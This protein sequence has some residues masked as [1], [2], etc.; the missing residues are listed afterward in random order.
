MAYQDFIRDKKQMAEL[1]QQM[2]LLI[3]NYTNE[4]L[5]KR[6]TEWIDNEF[7]ENDWETREQYED[8]KKIMITLLAD[9][10]LKRAEE[11]YAQEE[12]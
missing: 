9:E 6:L 3:I 12:V 8:R 4:E 2:R 1:K 7:M 10:K 11:E 5:D